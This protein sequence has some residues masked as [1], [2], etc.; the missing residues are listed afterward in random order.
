MFVE[1]RGECG[2][3]GGGVNPLTRVGV[4]PSA[5]VSE[6]RRKEMRNIITLTIRVPMEKNRRIYVV[7][8]G[9]G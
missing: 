5:A 3:R 6:G 1:E 8:A 4:R 2:H 7:I 9:A